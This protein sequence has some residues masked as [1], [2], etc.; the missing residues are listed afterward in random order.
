MN[1]IANR[2][3]SGV[4]KCKRA[5][6]I[7]TGKSLR[8]II[9]VQ[10]L[11]TEFKK[12]TELFSPHL[13]HAMTFFAR[14]PLVRLLLPFIT[15][16]VIA[17][18]LHVRLPLLP[19][20]LVFVLS[21][22]I[23]IRLL[24]R[25]MLSLRRPGLDG[26]AV[27][28]ALLTAGVCLTGLRTP[29]LSET[30]F[31]HH[32]A[33]ETLLLVRVSEAVALKERSVKFPA[34]VLALRKENDWQ[35]VSGKLLCYLRKNPLAQNLHYG[36]E[37][38]LRV[39]TERVKGP[40]NPG[41][42]DYSRYL[43]LHGIYHQAY[44]DSSAWVRCAQEKGNVIKA[45]ALDLRQTLLRV[46]ER[47][48]LSGQEYAVAAALVLGED[49]RIDPGLIKAYAASGALHVLS[50]SG[51]HVAIVYVVFNAL[52]SFL[53]RYKRGALLKAVLLLGLLWFYAALTGLSPSVLRSA[54]MFSFVVI[55]RSM[56]QQPSIFN[57]LA[58]SAFLLLLIE[59]YLVFDVGFQLSYLAVAGIVLLQPWF[60]EWYEP[61][62]WFGRQAWSVITVSLAAQLVTFPLGLY[63]F[64]QFP[65][66]FLLAN[67]VVIPLSTFVIYGGIALLVLS[68]LPYV[69][70]AVAW[71][72]IKTL[73]LLNA[74]VQLT[75]QLPGA[76]LKSGRISLFGLLLLYALCAGLLLFL[77]RKSL[78]WLQFTLS[79]IVLLLGEQVLAR[80]GE[81]ERKRLV[82]YSLPG[83][84]ALGF[85]RGDQHQL[86]ADSAFLQTS[87]GQEF[88]IQP[89]LQLCGASPLPNRVLETDTAF[90]D[91]TLARR[92]NL[93]SFSGRTVLI[94]DRGRTILQGEMPPP[95]IL[96]L[97]RNTFLPL[98]S[99]LRL[100][101]PIHVVADGTN[102][103]KRA[104]MW[105]SICRKQG[106]PF[107]NVKEQGALVLDF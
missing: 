103:K 97:R 12:S 9:R 100:Y 5:D 50:V 25:P 29:D 107:H 96:L 84:T 72:F 27:H 31:S 42:F 11:L 63:Y 86:L 54:A 20:A 55:G 16:I 90:T 88:H 89:H 52:L 40:M 37:L 67:L 34:E 58:A 79:C 44:A 47:F 70:D 73:Q 24:Q 57:T 39:K 36:D 105:D 46:Y 93:L 104:A 6:V 4:K 75:E 21:A 94:I 26:I 77:F 80:S 51:M 19:G 13:T 64:H 18:L 98:D 60:A 56:R 38:L 15:G 65:T 7:L 61:R 78:R 28:L 95:E 106:V 2:K 33:G 17:A 76:V 23:I 87:G 68:P 8:D 102:G 85:L 71:L 43:A 59:P 99:L 30:H 92:N 3:L 48:G 22:G 35:P 45:M 81:E 41:E 14:A 83:A 32:A 1:G 49:D 53:D 62:S 69:S 82:V 91:L 66:Y 74:A 101:H 10:T